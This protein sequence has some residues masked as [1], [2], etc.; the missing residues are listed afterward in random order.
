[1]TGR[2]GVEEEERG[3][4]SDIQN[5]NRESDQEVTMQSTCCGCRLS[6]VVCRTESRTRKAGAAEG[7][8]RQ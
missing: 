8:E 6:L 5:A 1:M 3:C 7:K 4:L 2:L